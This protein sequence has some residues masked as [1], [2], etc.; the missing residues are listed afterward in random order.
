MSIVEGHGSEV[1][2]WGFGVGKASEFKLI[3]FLDEGKYGKVYLAQNIRNGVIYSIKSMYRHTL[4]DTTM[5]Q[6][7]REVKIQAF[8]VHPNVVRL[9]HFF[10][11]ADCAY[12]V[13]EP[14]LGKN[15]YQNLK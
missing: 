6:L 14:C 4:D 13:L 5:Q 2:D 8:L 10:V 9:Y 12:L 1:L 7:L 3:K 15:L 11:D